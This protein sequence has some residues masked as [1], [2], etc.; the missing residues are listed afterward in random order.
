MA[1]DPTEYR[2]FESLLRFIDPLS[3][4]PRL[5]LILILTW[6]LA[7]AERTTARVKYVYADFPIVA[8]LWPGVRISEDVEL[9]D[10]MTRPPNDVVP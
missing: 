5:K 1:V 7:W 2:R 4:K 8:R 10:D 3:T 9:P 6:W